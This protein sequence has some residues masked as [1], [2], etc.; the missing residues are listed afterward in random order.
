MKSMICLHALL[1]IVCPSDTVQPLL[2]VCFVLFICSVL[3]R[4]VTEYK[5]TMHLIGCWQSTHAARLKLKQLFWQFTLRFVR[6][7]LHH[8]LMCKWTF[9]FSII[10]FCLGHRRR[11]GEGRI[12]NECCS[13]TLMWLIR[14]FNLLQTW[15]IMDSH[16][17]INNT[18]TLFPWVAPYML[19]S[20]VYGSRK[21]SQQFF[22][23]SHWYF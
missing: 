5:Y 20:V 23:L 15:Y 9:H 16:P 4:P 12:T 14:L 8:N 22:W 11:A 2:Y 1:K 19:C 17:L 21:H 18:W 7:D 3:S 10:K 13:N 6:S